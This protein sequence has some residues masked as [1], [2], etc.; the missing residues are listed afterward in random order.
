MNSILKK[1]AITPSVAAALIGLSTASNATIVTVSPNFTNG[2]MQVFALDGAGG[3]DYGAF[4]FESGWGVP[5]IK[6]T[7]GAS[8]IVLEAN[9]NTYADNAGSDYWRNNGG[10]GP[11]GNKWMVASTFAESSATFFTDNVCNFKTEISNYTF[12][13]G[14][15]VRAFIKCFA[16]DYSS[17]NILFSDPLTANSVVDL[18]LSTTGWAIVQYG[19]EV[20]GVN[21]NPDASP[22]SATAIANVVPEIVYGIPNP[23]FETPDGAQWGSSQANGHIFTYPTSGGNPG[24]YAVID[25]TSATESYYA[26]LVANSDQQLSLVS[27][28]LTAGQ[29]YTMAMDMKLL[30]GSNI[31]GLK[32]EYYPGGTNTGDMYPAITGDGSQWATYSFPLTIPVGTTGIKRVPLWGS[33]S[34]VAFDN[35]RFAG[36][37]AANITTANSNASVSW[38][39]VTG[40][41]YQVQKSTDLATWTNLGASESGDGSTKSKVDPITT[42]K[43]FFKVIETTP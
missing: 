13:P 5:V 1:L 29:K 33:F 2:F 36:P 7:V 39:S 41:T 31:G 43:S 37:F 18:T 24:G 42:T 40:R 38:P 35:V 16:G 9:Y 14:Y 30:A 15:T 28:S 20:Q 34:S 23:G 4:Q 10:A 8:S 19:F 32:V 6:S 21:A 26:V 3:P 22:G 25:G 17:N 11:G 27:L 12:T